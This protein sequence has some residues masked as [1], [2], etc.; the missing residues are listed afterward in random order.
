M[1]VLIA[2][3]VPA[4]IARLGSRIT[5][6]GS[7]IVLAGGLAWLAAAGSDAT[8]LAD[9]LGPSI[10][11]GV[12]LGGALV[13]ATQLSVDGVEGGES[14]LAGGLVN[15]SQQVGGA[16][17]LSVLATLAAARTSSL[18]RA[19]EAAA[20]ALAGGFSWLFIGAAALVLAAAVVAGVFT[21]GTQHD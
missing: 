19:G 20:D 15:T 3:V 9:L 13:T 17:G 12:G 8:Y 16:I 5:L 4:V 1:V 14:G 6:V 7:L 18:E 21:K 2:G 10:L 11:I